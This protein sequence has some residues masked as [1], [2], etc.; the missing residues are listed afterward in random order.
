MPKRKAIDDHFGD[1]LRAMITGN[2]VA[3][4]FSPGRTKTAAVLK[5]LATEA[6]D[7]ATHHMTTGPFIMGQTVL[8]SGGR[9]GGGQNVSCGGSVFEQ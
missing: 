7:S 4:K 3:T 1:L 8:S 6:T 9:G 2:R 5:T